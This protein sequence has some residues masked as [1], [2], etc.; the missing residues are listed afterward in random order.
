MQEKEQ[1][2]LEEQFH[3]V[4][5][6]LDPLETYVPTM[7]LAQDQLVRAG[8]KLAA[9]QPD[10]MAVRSMLRS[11]ATSSLR[12]DIRAVATYAAEAGQGQTATAAVDQCLSSIEE[13]DAMLL[14]ARVEK[15]LSLQPL[16]D[17]LSA[18]IG[19]LDRLLATVPSAA[20][21]KGNRIAAAYRND[22][23][24]S[25]SAPEQLSSPLPQEVEKR[26]LNKTKSEEDFLEKLL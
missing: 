1:H 13:L 18:A 2:L 15:N 23:T 11:G 25:S 26:G 4:K 19:A 3:V 14:N 21:D 22:S 20:F 5:K 8:R 17:K 24:P 9:P 7:I 12:G 16:Q 10:Y 6:K